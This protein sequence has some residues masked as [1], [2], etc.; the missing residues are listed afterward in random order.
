MNKI[1][2]KAG[3]T[4]Y[5]GGGLQDLEY[6][7]EN[8]KRHIEW[9]LFDMGDVYNKDGGVVTFGDTGKNLVRA[10]TVDNGAGGTVY[11]GAGLVLI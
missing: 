11:F 6:Y 2:N 9:S 8:G 5:F 1:D 7:D 4:T 10:G 3:G